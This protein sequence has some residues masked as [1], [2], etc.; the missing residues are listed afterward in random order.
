MKQS[1][2][3]KSFPSPSGA[4][5]FQIVS[6]ILKVIHGYEFPSPSGAS[7]FQ[8]RNQIFYFP[9]IFCFR[10]L[11]GHLISKFYGMSPCSTLYDTFP[12]PSGASHFQ[13]LSFTPRIPCGLAE[14]FAWE[15]QIGA[16]FMSSA[17]PK[18]PQTQHL[19]HAR[20]NRP[21]LPLSLISHS[22]YNTRFI[23]TQSLFSSTQLPP[24]SSYH[25]TLQLRQ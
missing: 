16:S 5:H 12:S 13:I 11:P 24:G 9:G 21:P 7:H 1:Q 23:I 10:P 8:I 17:S 22:H 2:A 25:R 6:Q 20:E 18:S 4:S 19:S 15:N 14:R 3:T